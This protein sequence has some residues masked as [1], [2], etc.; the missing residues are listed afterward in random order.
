MIASL[1]IVLF[2]VCGEPQYVYVEN[3]SK[4]AWLP[5]EAITS[6]RFLT[7]EMFKYKVL[8]THE[9]IDFHNK[10][11]SELNLAGQPVIFYSSKPCTK[12]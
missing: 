8:G 1:A 7:V 2:L 12:T 11:M 9:E 3:N 5:V 6:K 4:E 10:T